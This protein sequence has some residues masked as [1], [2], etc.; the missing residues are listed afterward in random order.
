MRRLGNGALL[1]ARAVLLHFRDWTRHLDLRTPRSHRS[2]DGE[3]LDLC[4]CFNVTS[5][6]SGIAFDLVDPISRYQMTNRSMVTLACPPSASIFG[7]VLHCT[8][9]AGFDRCD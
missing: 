7:A 8:I 6:I 5:L 9:L 2:Q 3:G 4:V 1:A